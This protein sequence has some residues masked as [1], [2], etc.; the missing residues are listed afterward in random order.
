M[1]IFQ[2]NIPLKLCCDHALD[3]IWSLSATPL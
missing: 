1:R 3:G 2:T